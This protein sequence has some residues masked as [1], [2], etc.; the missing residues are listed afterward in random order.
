[1]RLPP[2]R[3]SQEIPH[4]TTVGD[5]VG[6]TDLNIVSNVGPVHCVVDL[7]VVIVVLPEICKVQLFVIIFFVVVVPLAPRL[8]IQVI[9]DSFINC[10]LECCLILVCPPCDVTEFW[11]VGRSDV[12]SVRVAVSSICHTPTKGSVCPGYV[13]HRVHGNHNVAV[14]LLS[15]PILCLSSTSSGSLWCRPA[16]RTSPCRSATS[17][18][19][20]HVDYIY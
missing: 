11:Y 4:A 6:V 3:A 1:M 13:K 19:L 7:I 12:D 2:E 16:V 8:M 18:R 17:R 10:C 5:S 15:H 20:F 9:L 14:A